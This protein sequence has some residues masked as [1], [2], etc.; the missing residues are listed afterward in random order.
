APEKSWNT[1]VN[2]VKKIYSSRGNY[3]GMDGSV[4]YTYFTNRIVPDYETNPNQILYANLDGNAVSKGISVNFDAAWNSG[5]KIL[6][7]ATLM[8]VSLEEEGEKVRQLL[9]ER[10]SG[11]WTIGYR[12]HSIGLSM[13]YTGNVYS[14]M[15]LPLLGDLDD[16]PEYS[17]WW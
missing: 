5:F 9:T 14:P 13:D 2:L 3:F 10:F 8:D 16:R 4:F 1:N 7:G 11:V 17:S 15:R 6:A 12:F